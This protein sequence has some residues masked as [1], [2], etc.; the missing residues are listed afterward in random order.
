MKNEIRESICAGMY[1]Y[2]TLK[3]CIIKIQGKV[4]SLED[5][6]Y[7]SLYLGLLNTNNFISKSL[8][9]TNLKLNTALNLKKLKNEQ[10]IQIYNEYF[11]DILYNMDFNSFDEFFNYLLDKTVVKRLNIEYDFDPNEFI[12]K[13]N[14]RLIKK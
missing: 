5:K 11:K 8:Q 9:N 14:K 7:L 10:Y 12:D 13:S 6:K 2:N 3:N 1:I 4:V